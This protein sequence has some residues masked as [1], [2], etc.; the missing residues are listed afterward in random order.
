MLATLAKVLTMFQVGNVPQAAENGDVVPPMACLRRA[1]LSELL[2]ATAAAS[3][4]FDEVP[5]AAS[6]CG[7]RELNSPKH[8]KKK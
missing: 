7:A 3:N 2:D 1:D 6:K 5:A 4:F 8:D